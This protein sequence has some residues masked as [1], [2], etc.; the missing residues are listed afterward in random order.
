VRDWS[1]NKEKRNKFPKKCRKPPHSSISS[2]ECNLLTTHTPQRFLRLYLAEKNRNIWAGLD[3]GGRVADPCFSK[4]RTGKVM[5]Y[6][7][8]N[9]A[10]KEAAGSARSAAGDANGYQQTV[11]EGIA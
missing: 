10:A 2:I 5:N 4:S 9:G 1:V 3:V 6:D 11:A 8:V 7:H